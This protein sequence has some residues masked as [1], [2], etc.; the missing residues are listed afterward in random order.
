V[1]QVAKAIAA[2]FGTLATWGALVAD[3]GTINTAE[4]FGLGGVISTAILVWAVP[5][6]PA[7]A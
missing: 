2:F 4:W 7:D 1:R 5:N 3:D 6:A